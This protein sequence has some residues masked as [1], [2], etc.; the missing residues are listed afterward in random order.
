MKLVLGVLSSLFVIGIQ[1]IAY[2]W[3]TPGTLLQNLKMHGFTRKSLEV[4]L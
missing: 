1:G 2:D 3:K 4:H